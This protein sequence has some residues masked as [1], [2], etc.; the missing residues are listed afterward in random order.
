MFEFDKLLTNIY[1]SLTLWCH[2]NGIPV[3]WLDIF[4]MV[5]AGAAILAVV[6]ISVI[7][8]VWWERKISAHFQDRLGPMRTGWHGVLQTIV[9]AIKLIQKEDITP[10][11][12]DKRVFFWAPVIC[13]TAALA[14]FI[15]IPFGKGLI[16]RD[17]NIGILYILAITTFTVISILMAGYA[18]NN[19]YSLLGGM[20]SAAQVISYEVPL[21]LSVLGAVMLAGSLSMVDIVQAQ[22]PYFWKWY[23]LP[24]ILGFGI[25]FTAATAETNRTPF[26]LPEAE[27]E[28][29]AGFNIE[30]SGMKFALFFMAEFASM[31][32]V[33]AVATTLFLG[34]WQPPIP[35]LSF[36]P[37]W[38]WFVGKTLFLIF[39]MMWVKWTYPRLRVDQLMGF[40]W[41]FLLPLSFANIILTAF[42]VYIFK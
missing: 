35:G 32:A 2:A 17:L 26:D 27:Q 19:K 12:A 3:F 36:I 11:S 15:V 42:G 1:S 38:I 4:V 14:A 25:Y 28:L 22:G 31:F 29:V 8:L 24:Q 39:V 41:K 20:R 5:F 7:F 34:G 10:T 23:W 18:S 9:D 13:F 33:C 37:S 21:T 40:A 6:L 30:Y 16:A